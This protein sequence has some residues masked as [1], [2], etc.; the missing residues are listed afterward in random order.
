MNRTHAIVSIGDG[1]ER[2]VLATSAPHPD[3]GWYAWAE[4]ETDDGYA[5]VRGAS[6]ETQ[7]RAVEQCLA[8]ARKAWRDSV[9][10]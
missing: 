5:T 9:Q 6:A 1:R 4:I 10:P 3:G 7:Q 2:P 8:L